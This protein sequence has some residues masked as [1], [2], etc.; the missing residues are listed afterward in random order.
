MSRHPLEPVPTVIA[1]F[2]RATGLMVEELLQRLTA[3]GFP[4]VTAS[5]HLVFENLPPGGARLT[6]IAARA[7]MSH[8]AAGEL[9]AGLEA[10]GYL[11]RRSDP[12]DGRARLVLLT[13]EGRRLVRAA[14]REIVA[15]QDSWSHYLA[16]GGLSVELLPLLHG[17]VRRAEAERAPGRRP[18][19]VLDRG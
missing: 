13:S 10:R 14:L 16:T 2:R 6:E 19:S 17:A 11:E 15:I 7:G 9:V 5:E 4:D 18:G 3:A 8:Q 12:S 1:L